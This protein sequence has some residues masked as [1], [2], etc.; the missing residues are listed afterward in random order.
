MTSRLMRPLE[1]Q[2]IELGLDVLQLMTSEEARL[3]TGDRDKD[4]CGTF[5]CA[6]SCNYSCDITCNLTSAL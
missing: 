4:E 1:M 5:T 2:T 3:Y 6:V